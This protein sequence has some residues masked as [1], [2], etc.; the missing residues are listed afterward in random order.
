MKMHR[1]F[2]P[3]GFEKTECVGKKLKNIA[4]NVEALAAVAMIMFHLRYV[5]AIAPML[6]LAVV[7]QSVMKEPKNSLKK[8]CKNQNN[9]LSLVY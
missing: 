5:S 2:F 7:F 8:V 6:L 1:T 3:N 9:G 4:T